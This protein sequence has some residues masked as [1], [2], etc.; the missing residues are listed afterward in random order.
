[1]PAA[2][3]ARPA[4]VCPQVAIM[5][6]QHKDPAIAGDPAGFAASLKLDLS[7]LFGGASSAD[8][9]AAERARAVAQ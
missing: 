6:P 1:M 5:F 2:R 7:Q 3:V 4:R 8:L 9:A